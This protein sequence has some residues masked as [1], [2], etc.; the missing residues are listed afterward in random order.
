VAR[1]KRPRRVA[2]ML[3][4]QWP[5][6]RHL[7]VFL[8]TQR[9]AQDRPG[10]EC[11]IDEYPQQMLAG[12]GRQPRYDGIIARATSALARQARRYSVPVVNVWHNSPV[13]DLPA[14]YPDFPA[15]G[16]LAAAHLLDRGL[17]R[18][19]CLMHTANRTHRA[20]LGGFRAALYEAGYS[21]DV[22]ATGTGDATR[23]ETIWRRSQEMLAR[24]VRSWRCPVG[25]FVAFN[26]CTARFVVNACTRQGVRIPEDV[27]LVV[28]DNDLPFCLQLPP[29][30]TGIDLGYERAG[31]EAAR[32]L[33]QM[34]D[35]KPPPAEP[36]LVPGRGIHARQSTDFFATDDELVQSAMRFI[37]SHIQDP[38]S[39]D[40]IARGIASS[41]RTLERRFEQEAGRPVFAEVRRLRIERAKRLLLDTELP[42]KQVARAAGFAD[43]VQMYQ[44]FTRFVH[45]PP[46]TF[47]NRGS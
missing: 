21:G 12:R 19:A 36:V 38:M 20:M 45:V 5:L 23:N 26:D 24:W 18:F 37:A 2:L 32:L 22:L 25:V 44:V 31:Y 15:A 43:H 1:K 9:Y 3:E 42:M 33:D 7:D 17:R 34:M 47:R 11:V 41:R 14:V 10:W 28:A 16:R 4:L 29:T 46:S 35:G 6:R 13:Q 30:L 40:D 8:G 39:V 27:A